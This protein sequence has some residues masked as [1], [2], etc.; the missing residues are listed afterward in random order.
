[1]L[2]NKETILVYGFEK[3]DSILYDIVKKIGCKCIEV[4]KSMGKMTIGNILKASN[5]NKDNL[6]LTMREEKI[7]LFNGFSDKRLNSTIDIIRNSFD[8]NPILAV[9]TE[10]SI[11][12]AFKD[13]L[14]HLIEE[15]EW[16][17]KHQK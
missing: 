10:T 13:L 2:E 11:N 14:D 9:V 15:R 5:S 7:I 4:N 3:N 17:R 16:F 8:K 6:N 1:M 12:W